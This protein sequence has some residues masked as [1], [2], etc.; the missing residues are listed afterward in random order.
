MKIQYEALTMWGVLSFRSSALNIK[1][2]W[3]VIPSY[4]DY[5]IEMCIHVFRI[6]VMRLVI[7]QGTKLYLC[8]YYDTFIQKYTVVSPVYLWKKVEIS[9]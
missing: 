9:T 8:G 4:I 5:I 3:L 2:P 6:P 7:V 1:T